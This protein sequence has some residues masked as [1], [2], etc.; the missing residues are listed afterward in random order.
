MNQSISETKHN[1]IDLLHKNV[2]KFPD[3]LAI[4]DEKDRITYLELWNKIKKVSKALSNLGI[5][6]GD[7]VAFLQSNSITFVVIH[8]AIIFFE[9]NFC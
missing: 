6:E 1:F 2:K 7:R 8:F 4:C 5:L 3:K 9:N